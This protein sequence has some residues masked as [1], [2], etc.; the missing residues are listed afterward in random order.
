MGRFE[1]FLTCMWAASFCVVGPEYMAMVAGE[2][3]LPRITLPRAFK[4]VY[5]RFGI[6][7]VGGALAAGVVIPYNDKT[8]VK[9][10]GS[11]SGA[12]SPYV[13]A[14]Q[15]MGLHGLPS[16]VNALLCTSIY[17]AGNAYTY[18][19]SR[20]LHGLAH[21]GHAPAFL[22][23]CTKS[24]VPIYCLAITMIFPLLSLLQL[25]NSSDQVL[26]W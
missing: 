26:S 17:S 15:N 12:A 8:L 22:K 9:N 20:T 13:I 16:L 6:F 2:A 1:S 18:C 24:G 5:L 11:S 21:D 7:F 23:K 4:S 10:L 25:S 14:M 19:A 3:K